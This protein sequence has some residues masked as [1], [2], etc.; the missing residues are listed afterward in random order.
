MQVV[1][2]EKSLKSGLEL[3]PGTQILSKSSLTSALFVHL[4]MTK[5]ATAAATA[6]M[7]APVARPDSN[8][9][10]S[11]AA[12]LLLSLRCF[13]ELITSKSDSSYAV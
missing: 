6:P 12:A 11:D 9:L 4:L 7:A 5:K 3:R 1:K 13:L 8:P 10:F 2:I